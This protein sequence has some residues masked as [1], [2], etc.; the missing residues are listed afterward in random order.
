[1]ARV[2]LLVLLAAAALAAAAGP[3]LV[4]AAGAAAPD[5]LLGIFGDGIGLGGGGFLAVL[6]IGFA[7]YLGVLAG[8]D[9]LS[10]RTVAGVAATAIV[11]MTLAPPLLSQ[12]V[13]S[14]V[15]YERLLAE[16]GLD[17][18]SVPPSALPDPGIYPY[19]GWRDEVSAYGPLF[20]VATYPLGAI[21]VPAALWSFKA[22]AAVGVAITGWATVRLAAIRGV[23][24]SF[25]LAFVALNPLV[26]AHVVG[27][28]HNDALMA[29]AISLAALALAG[30]LTATGGALA[31]AAAGIKS[32]GAF[33][34]PFA[35]LGA[36]GRGRV[37]AG[38]AGGV[39]VFAG[40][41]LSIFGADFF[42]AVA[43]AGE[44]QER[45][46]HYSVPSQ[47]SRITGVDVDA[48]RV[49]AISLYGIALAWLA[50]WTRRGGDWLRAAGWA[51]FG[52]LVASA[53][54]LPWYVIWV[55]PLA[56]VSRDRALIGATLALT[57]YQLVNRVPL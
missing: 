27:G 1:M 26:L 4:P 36:P 23:T 25:A 34:A 50:L 51:A 20:T 2:S 31:V 11:L 42:E 56:A 43:L 24:P 40:V 30:G 45:T 33:L 3:D 21:G 14:Y 32:S 44:N 8:A 38:I 29:A 37:L 49:V 41:A 48:L 17:P 54:L 9:R 55:L 35:V 10:A 39:I 12:D 19:V 22:L 16:H 6:C 57:A 52:L 53:W 15:A 28:A 7:A 5:W 47:L 13:F 18:Y 46:S